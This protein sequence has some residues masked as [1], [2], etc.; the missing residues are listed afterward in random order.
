MVH[1]VREWAALGRNDPAGQ[2][3]SGLDRLPAAVRRRRHRS[4]RQDLAH[5]R[6]R[7]H[8][9]AAGAQDPHQPLVLERGHHRLLRPAPAAMR[10]S[11]REV[12]G[13]QAFVARTVWPKDFTIGGGKQR[14][15]AAG[16]Q[17]NAD[18]LRARSRRRRGKPMHETRLL[19]ERSPGKGAAING[20]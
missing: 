11:Y 17:R 20:K 14:S 16:C 13:A 9:A 10:G 1:A 4:G 18:H 12:D 8:Q 19:W 2:S 15:A 3:G 6:R 7:Q 5:A